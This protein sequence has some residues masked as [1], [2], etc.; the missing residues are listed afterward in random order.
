MHQNKDFQEN[1]LDLQHQH[2]QENPF[3]S[4]VVMGAEGIVVNHFPLILTNFK[5]GNGILQGHMARANPLWNDYD[6][7]VD[8]VAIFHGIH[9]YITPT[10]YPSKIEHDKVV[11]TWNYAV[12]HASGPLRIIQDKQWILQHLN[13]L[14]NIHE[15]ENEVP[16]SVND[17]PEKYIDM[18][19][20]GI[21]GFEISI[22]KI[23]GTMKLGQNKN[24]EDRKGVIEGLRATGR[25]RG[26]EMADIVETYLKK[27]PTK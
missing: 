26:L 20:R 27:R 6:K 1:N 16:W 24:E 3:A 8:V 15:K 10:Y 14:T 9:H 7:L 11:P 22:S 23:S 19:L 13:D 5:K 12:V 2:M 18:R 17:A 21:V 25:T 4:V